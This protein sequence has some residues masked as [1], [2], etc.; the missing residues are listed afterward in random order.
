MPNHLT[1]ERADAVSLGTSCGQPI[2]SK[3]GLKSTPA[4]A[5]KPARSSSPLRGILGSSGWAG[6]GIVW[7]GSAG[8]VCVYGSIQ[9]RLIQSRSRRIKW[10]R[11]F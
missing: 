8:L 3:S 11:P 6:N 5:Q 10:F 4:A 1:V 7:Q 2:G 9:V